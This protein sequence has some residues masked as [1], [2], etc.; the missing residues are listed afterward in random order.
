MFSYYKN[1]YLPSGWDINSG[2]GEIVQL[3]SETS[4]PE[5]E[6]GVVEE[7]DGDQSFT[8]PNTRNKRS[9]RTYRL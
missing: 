8:S 4:T 1:L 9:T 3:K 2:T 5:E 6:E 7:E